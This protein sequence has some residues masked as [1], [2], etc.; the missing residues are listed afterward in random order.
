MAKNGNVLFDYLNDLTLGKQ[1]LMTNELSEKLYPAFM[2]NRGLSQHL[3]TII[4]ANTMNK[5]PFL[6]NKMQHDFL[7]HGI[8]KRK[9]LSKWAKKIDVDG[10]EAI[11]QIYGYSNEK[12][13][14][15]LEILTEEEVTEIKQRLE[16]GGLKKR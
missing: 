7:F 1:N 6:D 11:K 14:A 15:A 9:R 12:A 8:S 16:V 10:I 4:F 5:Y 13:K 2:V 3:D